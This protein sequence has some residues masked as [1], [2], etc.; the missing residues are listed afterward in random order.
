MVGSI[1]C[2]DDRL[3]DWLKIVAEIS[4]ILDDEDLFQLRDP[5]HLQH[6]VYK[7]ALIMVADIESR[8]KAGVL[9]GA[10]KI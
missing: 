4:A 8:Y 5:V 6:E 1:L 9:Y 7:D 2:R 10:S 3:L